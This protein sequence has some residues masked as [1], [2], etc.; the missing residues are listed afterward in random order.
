MKPLKE[1]EVTMHMQTSLVVSARGS[2]WPTCRR[3]QFSTRTALVTISIQCFRLHG[4]YEALEGGWTEDAYVDFT[5]GVGQRIEL[6]DK[7]KIPDDL[8]KT[9]MHD[10][11]MNSLMACSI[12]VS[13]E[14][15]L[16]TS[17][18]LLIYFLEAKLYINACLQLYFNIWVL[19]FWP[20]V[21]PIG[22]ASKYFCH[23]Y[24]NTH[25]DCISMHVLDTNTL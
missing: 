2:N 18:R 14:H 12:S 8:F 10:Y 24:A 17:Q 19:V 20:P 1:D 22:Y 6:T 13:N 23:M 5:G 25:W 16:K 21:L 3:Y 11:T 9:L 15:C 4:S 7:R